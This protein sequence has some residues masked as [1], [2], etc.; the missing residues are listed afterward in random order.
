MLWL[1]GRQHLRKHVIILVSGKGP[2]DVNGT[3]PLTL[4]RSRIHHEAAFGVPGWLDHFWG[5]LALVV[6][7]FTSTDIVLG[8][9]PSALL[10][11]YL[12]DRIGR[13]VL[14]VVGVVGLV[15]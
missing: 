15:R 10:A 11:A 7:P 9:L 13:K 3:G 1:V 8:S 6:Y 4:C 2:P 14:M 5:G 12:I